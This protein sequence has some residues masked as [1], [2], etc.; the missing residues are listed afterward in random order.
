MST[1]KMTL[2][3]VTQS[4]IKGDI[5]FRC[6]RRMQPAEGPGGKIFPSTYEGGKY[7]EEMRIVD[8][9]KTDCVLIDS[10]QSQANRIEQALKQAFYKPGATTAVFPIVAVD[11]V[12]AGLPEVGWLTSLDAPHRIADAILRDSLCNGIKFR[13]SDEGKAFTNATAQDATALFGLCP[14]ALTLGIWDSTGPKGGLGTKIQRALVSE[15]VAFNVMVGVKTSSRIDPLNIA[16][17]AGP[18]FRATNDV[19][20]TIDPAIAIKSK[21]GQ[22]LLLY[23]TKDGK[24][25][26]MSIKDVED[27]SKIPDQGKPSSLNH[28]NVTPSFIDDKTKQIRTGGVTCDYA[29]QTTV[30]SLAALRRLHFPVANG[31]YAD[32]EAQTVLATLGICGAVLAQAD[33]DLRSRCVLVPEGPAVWEK[34]AA[35]GSIIAFSVTAD[36]AKSILEAAIIPA[37]KAGLPWH[38]KVLMLQP[39]KPLVDLVKKSREIQSAQTVEG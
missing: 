32:V 31:A 33:A 17:G 30:L 23:K 28:G 10:V 25:I 24:D 29:L 4:V 27:K 16:L 2:E 38:Q 34:I 11:F 14:L 12:S 37:T 22:E 8:G 15:I 18:I 6:R 7:A 35:D 5:A 13:D 21:N 3:T 19:G 20:F 26:Y 9:V 1:Q 39:S 36:E